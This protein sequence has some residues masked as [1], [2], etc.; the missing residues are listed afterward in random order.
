MAGQ[1]KEGEKS[2]EEMTLGMLEEL[3]AAGT[4]ALCRCLLGAYLPLSA[5][6]HSLPCLRPRTAPSHHVQ[7]LRPPRPAAVRPARHVPNTEA[8]KWALG[9]L[10]SSEPPSEVDME[11][12]R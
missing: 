4:C 7:Y 6:L 8:L 1:E 2:L 5:C 3:G 12:F 9:M 11:W 10:A